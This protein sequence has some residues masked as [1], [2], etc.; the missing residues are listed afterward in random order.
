MQLVVPRG[1]A[2]ALG[3]ATCGAC[4][5]ASGQADSGV[6]LITERLLEAAGLDS[7]RGHHGRCRS[8]IDTMPAGCCE[9]GELDA[10][11]WSGGLPTGAVQRRCREQFPIRLVPLGDLASAAARSRA[12]ARATT[13]RRSMPAD[14]YPEAQRGTAVP[15][16]AVPNLLVTTDRTRPGA[17][18]GRHPDGDR[19]PGQRSAREVHA[20]QLVDLRTAVFTDPLPLHEGARALLP[21][22]QAVSAARRRGAAGAPQR[23]RGRAARV[24]SPRR[25]CGSFGA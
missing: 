3:R 11:F 18:R 16:I 22:G 17:G 24:R 14:A 2:G 9:T 1:S 5:S 6:Q 23:R 8:G 15:T 10:F 7:D 25:P 12:A 4:G 21:L 20:A 19:Q 13:G